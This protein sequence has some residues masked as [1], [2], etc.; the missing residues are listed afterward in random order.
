MTEALPRV[1]AILQ[2]VGLGPD[3]TGVPAAVLEVARIRGSA[4]HAAIEGIVYKYLDESALA[5]DVLPRLDAYRRFVKESGYETIHTE[6]EVVHEAWRYRGHPD[7]VGWLVKR[8]AILDFKNMDSMDSTAHRAASLQLCA[9]RAAWNAQHPALPVD[10]LAVVQLLSD[11]T[12]R[13][14]EASIAEWE[15]LW[16]AA[17]MVFHAK[18]A[19]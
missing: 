4:V 19:R 9:Y 16:F 15:P 7:S 11:G 2:D 17:V 3:F 6:I 8:R 14:H 10:A 1:T 12:Y 5:E 18:A 13:V